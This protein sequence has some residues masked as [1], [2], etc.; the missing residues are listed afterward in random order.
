M[1]SGHLSIRRISIALAAFITV[2]LTAWPL[3]AAAR[4]LP[5]V[6]SILPQ[7]YF[8]QQI[9]GR[10]VKVTVMVPPGAS[11]ATYEPSPR[12]MAQ[13]SRAR[14][15]FA[16]GVPFE[17]VWLKKMAAASPDMKI[18]HTDR[19]IHKISMAGHPVTED[20]AIHPAEQAREERAAATGIPD[21]HIW[22]SPPLVRQQARCIFEALVQIDPSR[23][24]DYR[25]RYERFITALDELH[26]DLKTLFSDKKAMPFMVFHPS[27]GYF[28]QA[29][30]LKQIPIEIEGKHPKPAH[31]KALI[32]YAVE[33]D[34]RVIFVQPQFSTRSATVVAQAID[35]RV[36][37]ADPLAEDWMTNLRKVASGFKAAL[38]REG[39]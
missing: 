12:Q 19:D 23:E 28:A 26:A 1:N 4:S 2:M 20:Q 27:W 34:I 30:G 14:L 5:V 17:T 22:L 3:G 9:G 13:L 31:L 35:G 25:R 11:P 24:D 36:V 18:V 7:Q 33:K 38:R 6:V 8:V 32:E 37:F 15:Y 21:P 10:R 29:Y 39:R 16:I